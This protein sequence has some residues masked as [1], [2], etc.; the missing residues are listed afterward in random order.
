MINVLLIWK[1]KKG[2]LKMHLE[3]KT[4]SSELIYHGKIID[5]RKDIAELENGTEAVR[6]LGVHSGGV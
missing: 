4:V 6:E 5:L 3:E 1:D 2:V